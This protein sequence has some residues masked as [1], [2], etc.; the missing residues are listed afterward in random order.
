MKTADYNEDK[1]LEIDHFKADAPQD[2]EKTQTFSLA[3]KQWI[4]MGLLVEWL[5]TN[6][7]A[8]LSELSEY[9]ESQAFDLVDSFRGISKQ[10]KEQSSSVANI[11]EQSTNVM[12]NGQVVPLVDLISNLDN[13]MQDMI[14]DIVEI[15]KKAMHMVYV[16]RRVVSDS[17][18]M[19]DQLGKIFKITKDTKY[20]AI[21]ASIEAAC[22]GEAG[23]GFSVVANEVNVLSQ[24]TEDLANSMSSMIVDF[25]KQLKEGF[26]LLEEIASKDLTDQLQMKEEIDASLQAMLGQAEQQRRVLEDNVNIS[27]DI[28]S[29]VSSLIMSMQFQDY[30]KQRLD[31]I[32]QVNESLFE[33]VQRLVKFTKDQEHLSEIETELSDDVINA[34]LDKFS[35]SKLKNEFK[36]GEKQTEPSDADDDVFFD[37]PDV[38]GAETTEDDDDG[39]EL[40]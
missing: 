23:R 20:L 2:C 7:N 28:N 36:T 13:L 37:A 21:N 10:A 12:M 33:E 26:G 22:A 27:N 4:E 5:A 16:M 17:E 1:L 19:Q 30:T 14:H 3:L 11:V 32:I 9:V 15:S 34:L 35:L 31:H 39:I 8:E 24:D 6:S 29:K 18:E 40:F 25:N 38:A